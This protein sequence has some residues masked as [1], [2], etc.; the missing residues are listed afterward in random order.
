MLKEI[1]IEIIRKCPNRCVHCSSLACDTSTEIIPFEKFKEVIESARSIGLE[2]VCFSGGEPFLHPDIIDMIEYV[3]SMGL[4]SFVYT[5][6]IC[7][8]DDLKKISIPEEILCAIAGK[9]T[10][11]IFNIEAAEE[12]TYN[13]IMGTNGC[14][15]LLQ[16]S[17]KKA[18]A[19][20]I[21][22]EG[23]FVPMKY[24]KDQIEQTLVMCTE[25]GI[26]KVS[27]LRLV[28][29]GRAL[30]NQ[31]A[32]VLNDDE[33]L[34]VEKMLRTIYFEKKYPIRIGVPLLGETAESHCEAANAKLNIRYDGK[35]FPCEVFKNCCVSALSEI[36]PYS[37]YDFDLRTIYNE[38]EYLLA[39]RDLV[40][41]FSGGNCCENCVGQYYMK[42]TKE[43]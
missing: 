41:R 14:F 38:S 21:I 30:V 5:S 15:G 18:V 10:K 20:E 37:I 40:Q 13:A 12:N 23:H 36:V 27:F 1:S 39:A 29:H 3:R 19:L 9:V 16:E 6:G 17:I 11:L 33:L 7:F 22:V 34:A 8:D 43:K 35:V 31:E 24:N 25:L 2:T 42:G 28:N 32:I 4:Q 26:S